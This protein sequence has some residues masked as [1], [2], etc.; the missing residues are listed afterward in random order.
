MQAHMV[1]VAN[2]GLG[3]T[4]DELELNKTLCDKHNVPIA[5]VIINKVKREKYDQ[6]QYYLGKALMDRWGI[7]LLGVV[8]DR[9]FL[10]CPALA[11]VENLFPGAPLVSGQEHRLRH[12]T[13][14]SLNLVATSLE[15]F[16]KNLR[17]DPS[18]TLYV[19]HASRNDILLGFLMESQQRLR[20]NETS[21]WEAA[22]VV[23]GCEDFPV[24]TQVLEIITSMPNAPPV[25]LA[26][27]P[28][29]QVMHELIHYTPKLNFQDENRVAAAID[30]YEPY[31]NF[32]LLL[33]RRQ[34]LWEEQQQH[35]EA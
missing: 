18:R 2:G 7:P 29:R 8:A 31:I 5:G 22:L 14:D 27:P 35:K 26:P 10:G 1:L 32:D 24:S 9:N 16:L 13:V 11:D 23:T 30:H 4:I 33:E 6:T 19:C 12:Y 15:V 3:N 21:E 20:K 34:A 17:T 25:L 28:T